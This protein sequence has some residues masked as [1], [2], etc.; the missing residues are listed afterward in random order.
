MVTDFINEV[1]QLKT[2]NTV[3][4]VQIKHSLHTVKPY[5]SPDFAHETRGHVIHDTL[6]SN[7]CYQQAKTANTIKNSVT[8]STPIPMVTNA[9]VEVSTKIM[10]SDDVIMSPYKPADSGF[11]TVTMK[12]HDIAGVKSSVNTK[13]ARTSKTPIY[14]EHTAFC[15]QGSKLKLCLSH[16][17]PQKPPRVT[18]GTS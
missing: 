16:S 6:S 9:V 11:I 5:G 15:P 2:E 14:E 12:K 1:A 18:L 7:Q 8:S 3:L 17:S 13:T 10:G 4:I